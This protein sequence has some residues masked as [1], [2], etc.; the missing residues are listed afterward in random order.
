VRPGPTVQSDDVAL[1]E[2]VAQPAAAGVAKL[3][4]ELVWSAGKGIAEQPFSIEG[5]TFTTGR[6]GA[7]EIWLPANRRLALPRTPP[8]TP[9]GSPRCSIEEYVA[10]LFLPPWGG[11]MLPD[12]G[13]HQTFTYLCQAPRDP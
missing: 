12:S 9:A 4:G 8:D 13:L 3:C 2:V 6:H 11:V 1:Y 10:G 5:T 7:Y